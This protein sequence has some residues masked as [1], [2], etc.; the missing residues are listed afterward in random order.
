MMKEAR[1]DFFVVSWDGRECAVISASDSTT[2]LIKLHS[3]I[4]QIAPRDNSAPR[5][6]GLRALGSV[7]FPELIVLP[8]ALFSFIQD[9]YGGIRTH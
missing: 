5:R 2:A 9:R 7:A 1:R 8:D 6:L 3:L 4:S